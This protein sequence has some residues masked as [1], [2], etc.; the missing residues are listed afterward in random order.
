MGPGRA[1]SAMIA[2]AINVREVN[3]EEAA[4]EAK[5]RPSDG[6]RVRGAV[7]NASTACRVTHCFCLFE[8][9]N[10]WCDSA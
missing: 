2:P 10:A 5:I 1:A 9:T 4:L 7:T 6:R 8:D 3:I